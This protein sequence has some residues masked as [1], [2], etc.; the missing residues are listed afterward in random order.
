MLKYIHTCTFV[1]F[2]WDN[3]VF[4]VEN[5]EQQNYQL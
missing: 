1:L 4:L 3:K 5:S 2:L